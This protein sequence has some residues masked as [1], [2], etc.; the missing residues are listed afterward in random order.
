MQKLGFREKKMGL[1][2]IGGRLRV[3]EEIGIHATNKLAVYATQCTKQRRAALL[4]VSGKGCTALRLRQYR[5]NLSFA[6]S[7]Q[8]D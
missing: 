1:E 7:R 6:A 8:W 2:K 5:Q 4:T 3:K